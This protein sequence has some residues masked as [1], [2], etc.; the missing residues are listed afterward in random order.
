MIKFATCCLIVIH[1][2]S[3][4]LCIIFIGLPTDVLGAG[5]TSTRVYS[6]LRY[7]TRPL[8]SAYVRVDYEFKNLPVKLF[9]CCFV[10]WKFREKE[11]NC[12]LKK[13]F[14]TI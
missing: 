11:K 6:Q 8:N 7:H 2:L 4:W 3:Q 9:I 1:L 13:I 12:S 5:A 14:Y 10:S